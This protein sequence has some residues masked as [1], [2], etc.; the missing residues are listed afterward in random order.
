M[1]IEVR[2][3]DWLNANAVR[4]YPL[5]DD[6]TQTDVTGTFR[7]PR[8]LV[9]ELRLSVHAGLNIDPA[10]FHLKS[11]GIFGSGITLV[12]GYT[13]PTQ[14]LLVASA[15]IPRALVT[16]RNV[17]FRLGGLGDFY[18]VVGHVVIGSLDELQQQPAGQ[19]EFDLAG[20]RLEQD[21]IVPN[22][23]NIT[24]I[25]VQNGTE[26]SEPYYGNIVLQAGK[27]MR[28]TPVTTPTATVIVFDAINS[29]GLNE[30]YVCADQNLATYVRTI[31]SI[32]PAPDGN[33][34]LL[35][36]S[37]CLKI[38]PIDAGLQFQ[39]T[40]S[41]PCCGCKELE[42]V[43]RALEQFGEQKT[44]LENFLVSLEARVTQM[45]QVVLGS[46]LG[47]RGCGTEE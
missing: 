38:E 7:L 13:T 40:C 47:D 16:K 37:D 30:P 43:T 27:N 1:A 10:R 44:T 42:T 2:M 11:I 28:I 22:I 4:S 35:S 14:T 34:T 39:D 8:S 6:A 25:Q 41:E 12:I 3:Q 36:K 17:P 23:R 20:G 31:N 5:C 26:I 9:V 33:F 32:P 18:D 15:M 29:T 46:R 24:S 19:W 45:D 21:A